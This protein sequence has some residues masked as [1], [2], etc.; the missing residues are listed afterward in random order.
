MQG[1][2]QSH[3]L[4]SQG[5]PQLTT[6]PDWSVQPASQV[7]LARGIRPGVKAT[8]GGLYLYLGPP[9]RMAA[10][11]AP[12]CIRFSVGVC[13]P[14]VSAAAREAAADRA[15]MLPAQLCAI[16]AKRYTADETH[17]GTETVDLILSLVQLTAQN[18]SQ[19]T[20]PFLS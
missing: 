10:R 18:R 20:N 4:N 2:T 16:S 12:G 11:E 8:T 9:E 5:L 7:S 1:W 19:S 6:T 17:I 3:R 13:T 14:P 15:A